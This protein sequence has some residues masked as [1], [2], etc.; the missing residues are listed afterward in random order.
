[1]SYNVPESPK[2]KRGARSWIMFIL[3]ILL[4]CAALFIFRII[5]FPICQADVCM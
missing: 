1:M 4:A 3:I 5:F 2:Q